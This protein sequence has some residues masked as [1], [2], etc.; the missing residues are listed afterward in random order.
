[1]PHSNDLLLL[2]LKP[3][4][5]LISMMRNRPAYEKHWPGGPIK[6]EIELDRTSGHSS[7]EDQAR[8][9]RDA[10]IIRAALESDPAFRAA[11]ERLASAGVSH[12]FGGQCDPCGSFTVLR[13]AARPTA[14][15]ALEAL[16]AD[17]AS[18]TDPDRERPLHATST[19]ICC[20]VG[21]SR[22][23]P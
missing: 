5:V 9:E 4:N 1:M 19:S 11:V 14:F 17:D 7:L 23:R 15:P 6:Q 12:E 22:V 8:L 10:R 20:R 13:L 3:A 21:T 16:A 2:T 18:I